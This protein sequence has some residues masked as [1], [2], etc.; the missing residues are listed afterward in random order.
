MKIKTSTLDR[1]SRWEAFQLLADVLAFAA[2]AKEDASELFKTVLNAL[3]GK[4]AVYDQVLVKE[5]SVAP[6]GLIAADEMRDYAVRKL[7]DVAEL[8]SNYSFDTEKEAAANLILQTF[9]LYGTGRAI[10][11]QR[12]DTETAIITNLLQ[13]LANEPQK[14]AVSGL[15]ATPIVDEL[16]RHNAVFSEAQQSRRDQQSQFVSGELKTARTE[17][18]AAFRTFC[19]TINA[20]AVVEGVE[21]YEKLIAQINTLV[22][23]YNAKARMR[24][25]KKKADEAPQT[26]Q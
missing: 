7:Y 14:Q 26:E 9:K 16:E 21:K 15:G 11:G 6:E 23:D 4:H 8:Y 3:Q 13:D 18:Q 22:A 12:Q 20:L 24:Q 10:A 25:N 19:N 17:V 5:R 1:L 2:V